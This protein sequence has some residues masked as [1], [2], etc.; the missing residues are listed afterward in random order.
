MNDDEIRLFS[1]DSG[2]SFAATVAEHA[3]LSLA[4]HEEREFED[5][6]HKIR[7]LVNCRG[8]DIYLIQSLYG[9]ER[10]SVNDKL[11]RL[12]FFC[13]AIRDAG[14]ERV[15][16]VVPYLCYARKDR[17]TK[18]RDP[19]TLRYVA[20]M[21]ESVGID[22]VV[23]TD[24]HNLAAYQN[25][26]RCHTEHLEA[27]PRMV[28]HFRSIVSEERVVVVS[29]D[30]GG[31]HRA[32]QFRQSLARYRQTV[33]GSAFVEKHRS[34]GQISGDTVV[35]DVRDA[36]VIIVDDLI[37]SGGTL[38]RAAR[39]LKQAG[40]Q[41]IFTVATHAAFTGDA[42]SHLAD[43]AIEGVVITDTLPPFRLRQSFIDE[44]LTVLPIAPM[45]AQAIERLHTGGSLVELNDLNE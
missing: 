11:C 21:F 37:A 10:A 25:A 32:E 44:H 19:L 41:R 20:G 6:E 40:A 5:G 3:G 26:F 12:L 2:R 24:V 17:K 13:G 35:G 7:P 43:P 8:R 30:V 27:R 33:I 39:T 28:E 9:D 15:T 22:R 23:T 34:G 29:P 14:A 38:A 1:L 45:I 4:E 42:E 31:V 18:S 36:T 16:A